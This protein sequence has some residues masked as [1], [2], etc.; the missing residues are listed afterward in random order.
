MLFLA[1][2][3]RS[4]QLLALPTL[5]VLGPAP[6][7]AAGAAASEP[8]IQ[9]SLAQGAAYQARF[10]REP[11]AAAYDRVL[12]VAPDNFEALW[13]RAV[14][15]AQLALRQPDQA[16]RQTSF[17]QARAL[18]DRALRLDSARHEAHYAV[19]LVAGVAQMSGASHAERLAAGRTVRWHAGRAVALNPRHAES[20][21]LL[22]GWHLG[23]ANLSWA[24]RMVAGP[25]AAGASNERALHCCQQALRLQP[26]N[27]KFY[28]L[29]ATACRHLDRPGEAQA[30]LRRALALPDLRPED[31]Q[32]RQKCSALLRE[33]T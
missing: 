31:P 5:L 30:L 19:A 26:G 23:L 4:M 7:P 25:A 24:E 32:V 11:A 14:L 33:V 12:R 6:G 22:G 16:A 29:A 17:R 9:Q 3:T 1:L 18:A 2:C 15:T 13:N 28:L 8:T 20:W 27:L 10:Q 21:A